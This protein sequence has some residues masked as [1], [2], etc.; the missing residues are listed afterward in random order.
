MTDTETNK[1]IR[2][3]DPIVR[4]G[5]WVL[6]VGF[7]T[8]YFAGDAFFQQHLWAGY[9][10]AVTVLVRIVWGFVGPKHA[11]FSSFV[12]SPAAIG[13]Y[14]GGLVTGRAKRHVGHNPAGGAMILALLISLA[15]TAGTGMALYAIED[16][17][18]PLAGIVTAS[19]QQADPAYAS[20]RGHHDD[21]DED[22]AGEHAGGEEMWEGLHSF[23]V[24]LTLA[25]VALHVAGVVFSS[26]SHR[27]NLV[28]A[29]VTGR[30]RPE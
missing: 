9:A 22:E 21:D 10:V 8:A 24:Y 1:K 15:G 19:P 28:R 2:V 18:G 17:K 23:F 30:K 5:H 16:N 25:L 26:L 4:I 14:L 3:W 20:A 29:M 7:F 11:R 13:A 27:E 12:R 6:V